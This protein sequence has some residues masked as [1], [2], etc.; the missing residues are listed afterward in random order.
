MIRRI[1]AVLNPS[2]GSYFKITWASI[3]ASTSWMQA[4]LYYGDKDRAWFQSEPGPTTDLQ[5]RLEKAVEE[6]WEKYLREGVQETPD[7]SFSTP[8]WAGTSSRLQYSVGQPEPRH[9][10]EAESIPPRFSRH[11]HKTQEEQEATSRYRTP[12]EDD[13]TPGTEVHQTIDEE[14]G[15]KDVTT[16]GEDWFTPPESEV[17]AA[18][19]N[20]LKLA[21]TPMDVDSPLEERSYQFFNGEEAEAFGPYQGPGSPV[22]AEEN[23][24]LDTPGGFSRA[25]GDGRPPSGSPAG[26]SGRRITGR[27]NE[28]Q[29]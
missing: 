15:A 6:R 2:F 13:A 18:V 7:L 11:D 24:V 26:P 21:A 3:A 19:N 27:T 25:P 14:L 20:L 28:G 16:I 4:R 9:P 10:T 1:R 22:T 5:N 17:A 29:E 12:A 8:S 23:H